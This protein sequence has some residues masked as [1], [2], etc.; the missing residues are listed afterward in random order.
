MEMVWVIWFWQWRHS[1]GLT[2]SNW[3]QNWVRANRRGKDITERSE[4]SAL[5]RVPRS[6]AGGS[7]DIRGGWS[8][9]GTSRVEI[10]TDW[11]QI[12]Y[13]KGQC[14]ALGRAML[15]QMFAVLWESGWGAPMTGSGEGHSCSCSDVAHSRCPPWSSSLHIWIWWTGLWWPGH[16]GLI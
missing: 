7:L 13:W 8:W 10:R 14:S 5:I 2:S 16:S 6:L 3:S 15:Y 11:G 9:W 12:A 1:L 4:K